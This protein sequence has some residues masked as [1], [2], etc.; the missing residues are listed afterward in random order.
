[1][2]SSGLTRILVTSLSANP[3]PRVQLR[4]KSIKDSIHNT[5]KSEGSCHL[6]SLE[7]LFLRQSSA[8]CYHKWIYSQSMQREWVWLKTR[9]DLT[10]RLKPDRK[11]SN[12]LQKITKV[13]WTGLRH[14]KQQYISQDAKLESISQRKLLIQVKQ[15]RRSCSQTKAK[16]RQTAIFQGSVIMRVV[17]L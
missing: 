4:L 9:L 17:C 11:T 2:P 16:A 14:L 13:L 8:S 7:R 12:S 3:I 5:L 1:M 10:R 6:N 15:A